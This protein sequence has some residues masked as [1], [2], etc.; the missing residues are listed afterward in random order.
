MLRTLTEE[1]GELMDRVR[2]E[3]LGGSKGLAGRQ[4]LLSAT[5]LFERLLWLLRRL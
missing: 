3:L 2:K 5:L 4:A 1:R